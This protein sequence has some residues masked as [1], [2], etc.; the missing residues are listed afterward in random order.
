[1]MFFGNRMTIYTVHLR[2]GDALVNQKPVFVK[3]GFNFLCFAF[4]FIWSLYNR[5]WLLAVAFFGLEIFLMLITR[6]EILA[7]ASVA[8][9]SM[10]IHIYSGFAANDWLRARLSRDGYV[11]T[12]I[13]V[14]DSQLRAEQRYFERC[15]KPTQQPA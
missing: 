15:L 10:S 9:F 7:I 14:A 1:M 11:L 2:P 8:S 4:P 13:T 12:D 6:S 5:L 3:E